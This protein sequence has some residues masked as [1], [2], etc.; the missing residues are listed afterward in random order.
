MHYT[1]QPTITVSICSTMQ[2]SGDATCMGG[3][4]LKVRSRLEEFDQLRRRLV[5]VQLWRCLQPPGWSIHT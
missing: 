2:I 1:D 5:D 3:R 4:D